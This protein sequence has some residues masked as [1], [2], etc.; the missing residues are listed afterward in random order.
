MLL[1]A[2]KQFFLCMYQ[3]L[4]PMFLNNTLNANLWNSMKFTCY[5]KCFWILLVIHSTEIL[6][7]FKRYQTPVHFPQFCRN[8]HYK[9]FE[10][11][12]KK[13]FKSSITTVDSNFNISIFVWYTYTYCRI[14]NSWFMELLFFQT[15]FTTMFLVSFRAS[16]FRYIFKIYLQSVWTY[17]A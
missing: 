6:V 13:H 15:H 9:N 12:D 7:D 17:F 2:L 4:V 10:Y 14:F 8:K 3:N 5:L 16:Y 11:T 1:F